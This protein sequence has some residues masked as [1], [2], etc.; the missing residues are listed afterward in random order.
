MYSTKRKKS[1]FT[2][3]EMLTV[4]AIIAI[5]VAI[6]IPVMSNSLHKAK[7]AADEANLRD[8]YAVLQADYLLTGEYDKEHVG[9]DIWKTS[10]VITYPDGKTVE[11]QAGKFSVIWPNSNSNNRVKDGYQIWYWCDKGDCELSLGV[12]N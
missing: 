2:L 6:M 9:D 10:S 11:L 1:G 8:Y 5:L 3:M 7:V 12:V 4:V